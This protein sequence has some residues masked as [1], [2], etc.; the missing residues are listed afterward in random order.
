MN[1]PRKVSITAVAVALATANF[2]RGAASVPDPA[3]IPVA[4]SGPA[5]SRVD[6]SFSS[7]GSDLAASFPVFWGNLDSAYDR[8]AQ[9]MLAVPLLP[10]SFLFIG[11]SLTNTFN[12]VAPL[13]AKATDPETRAADAGQ[14]NETKRERALTDADKAARDEAELNAMF[15]VAPRVNPAR[16]QAAKNAQGERGK[17]VYLSICYACH[18]P[19]G[20]GLPGAF[21]MLA[22]SDYMAADRTRAIRVV[23]GGLTGPVTVNGQTING[24]M[25][26]HSTALTDQ[27]IADVLTYVFNA[28]ENPGGAFTANQVETVRSGQHPA[29]FVEPSSASTLR[30]GF[31]HGW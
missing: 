16:T 27:Q 3:A 14:G 20:R 11:H 9:R 4:P 10:G 17:Q 25:P 23:L 21:P 30:P 5:A 7:G 12:P 31:F 8:P 26:A 13:P 22:Q 29:V 19:D 1:T 28:W 15:A 24:V 6:S 18:Q 2:L